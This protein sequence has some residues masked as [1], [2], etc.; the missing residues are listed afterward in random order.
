MYYTQIFKNIFYKKR[1]ATFIAGSL[2]FTHNYVDY[3]ISLNTENLT[4]GEKFWLSMLIV[5]NKPNSVFFKK[6]L[7]NILE[8]KQYEAEVAKLLLM[9]L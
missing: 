8:N 3:D 9:K 2:C 5:Q 6:A 4:P 7:N 1:G